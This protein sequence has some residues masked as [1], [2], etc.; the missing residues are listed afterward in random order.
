ML[1]PQRSVN[2]WITWFPQCSIFQPSASES[3]WQPP[4]W[5]GWEEGGGEREGQPEGGVGGG[6]G[7]EGSSLGL[8]FEG[9]GEELMERKRSGQNM[10]I[11][12]MIL[13]NCNWWENENH[14]N[15]HHHHCTVLP[16]KVFYLSLTLWCR[17]KPVDKKLANF[18]LCLSDL[19][20]AVEKNVS[21][22]YLV[23]QAFWD[24][25]DPTTWCWTRW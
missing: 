7:L 10:V 12:R 8:H 17:F 25:E 19:L 20:L 23:N 1:Y 4:R 13:I 9:E 22:W 3:P 5:W 11:V 24:F 14:H 16:M 2:W 6:A 18:N 21:R 15:H